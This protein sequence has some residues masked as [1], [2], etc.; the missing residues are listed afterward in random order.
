MKHFTQHQHDK[1]EF[2]CVRCSFLFLA[3]S[4]QIFSHLRV[5]AGP[6]WSH[7]GHILAV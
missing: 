3:A 2:G 5:D 1:G 6:T 4:Y 7:L